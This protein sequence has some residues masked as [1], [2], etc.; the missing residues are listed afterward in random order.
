MQI[1]WKKIMEAMLRRWYVLLIAAAL[2]GIM[3]VVAYVTT[4]PH[5]TVAASLM[6]R[7]QDNPQPAAEMMNMMGLAGT[8][9]VQDEVEVLASRRI[10]GEAIRELGMQTEQRRKVRMRWMGEYGGYTCRLMFNPQLLDTL[11]VVA[12]V[13][14]RFDGAAYELT[15]RYDQ[16]RFGWRYKEKYT[17]REGE[18]VQTILGPLSIQGSGQTKPFKLRTTLKPMAVAIRDMQRA[19]DVE[20]VT[21]ESNIVTLSV[22]TDMPRMMEDFLTRVI[23]LYND[24]SVED[25]NMVAGQSAVF[26]ADRL[27]VVVGQLDSVEQ[28]VENY[29]KQHLI[30]DLSK[31]GTMYMEA[32]QSYE[33]RLADMRTQLRLIEYIRTLLSDQTDETALIPANLNMLDGS[34]QSLIVDY[35]HLVV[36]HIRLSQSASENNPV[37]MQQSEQIAQMR[38]NILKSLDGQKEGLEIS[39]NNLKAQQA[40]WESKIGYLS[41]Q[42]REYVELRRQQQLKENQYLYLSQKA[43]ETGVMLAST[44]LPVKVIDYPAVLPDIVRPK[45]LFL[46]I[47]WVMIMLILAAGGIFV[48]DILLCKKADL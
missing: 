18:T 28:A 33:T 47:Q 48:W 5:F 31:E 36:E 44:A 25:K 21:L 23:M 38:R 39:M 41:T 6:L 15:I 37:Y 1:D 11:K 13:D 30:T 12:R 22:V 7:A 42:E 9:N 45:P 29:R 46:L 19:V 32:S 43:E 34:L 24:F 35:N 2:G 10:Y 14:T 17:L 4:T 26:I 16:Q 3:A 27:N 20:S 40:S 8:S